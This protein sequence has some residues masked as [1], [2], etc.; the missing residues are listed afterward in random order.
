ME[1]NAQDE[2]RALGEAFNEMVH[3][4][5]ASRA[6]LDHQVRENERLLLSLLPASAAAQVRGGTADAPKSF[7]DVTVA[8]ASLSG[9]DSLSPQLGEDQSM[10]LLSDIVAAFDEAAEQHGVEKVR[11]IGSSYLAASGLSV[12]R[13]DHTARVV[14]F[15]REIVAHRPP[16]QRRAG[17]GADARGRHQHRPDRRRPGRPAQV[18]LRPVGRHRAARARH[19]GQGAGTI[20]VTR[21]VYDRVR[22]SVPFEPRAPQ[23]DL[24]GVG[25]IELYPVAG[26][27]A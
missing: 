24:R 12:D 25:T 10:S 21:A 26:D 13:P 1:V 27:A 19:R 22:E 16:L 2:F 11:T 9:F 23:T 8:Y 3:S 6:A 4:L 5:G 18:H 20:V 15:A 14:E 17:D 7:A